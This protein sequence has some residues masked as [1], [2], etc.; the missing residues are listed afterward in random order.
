MHNASKKIN[1]C[2][3]KYYLCTVFAV[4]VVL[5]PSEVLQIKMKYS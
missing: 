4:N 2:F 1:C 5:V 3:S